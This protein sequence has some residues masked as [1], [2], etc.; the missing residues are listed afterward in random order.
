[1]EI[2]EMDG[3]NPDTVYEADKEA[4]QEILAAAILRDEVCTEDEND[5]PE[6]WFNI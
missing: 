2:D 6:C 5:Q 4:M 3:G 1:M